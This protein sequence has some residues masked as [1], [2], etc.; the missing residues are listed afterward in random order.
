LR[1]KKKPKPY[2]RLP[3]QEAPAEV[4]PKSDSE[5]KS[6]PEPDIDAD[7][8][9]EH[10]EPEF[11][12]QSR[13]AQTVGR[14]VRIAMGLGS[15]LLLFGALAQ[16]SYSF[17]DQIAARV[18]ETKPF[19][20]SACVLLNC[21]IGL[22]AQIEMI[23][24]ESDQLETLNTNKDQSELTMLLRNN[25]TIVQAWPNLELTLNDANNTALSRRVFA[26]HEYL[27][28]NVDDKKGFA[29][30]SEQPVKI[31]FDFT[32]IKPAGYHVGVFYP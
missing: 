20:T 17:R 6:E 23:S 14:T 26:P 22:P 21:K 15:F 10:D 16:A 5:S 25:A 12:R 7:D 24:I 9:E 8:P 27:P 29:S 3:T 2:K 1:G 28:A 18:P 31:R 30:N 19:L 11:V 4:A 13:R 32:G